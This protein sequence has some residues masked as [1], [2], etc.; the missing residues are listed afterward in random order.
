MQQSGLVAKIKHIWEVKSLHCPFL[1]GSFFPE[2]SFW[3]ALVKQSMNRTVNRMKDDNW[4]H[5]TLYTSSSL[6]PTLSKPTHQPR[7]RKTE[8]AKLKHPDQLL[9]D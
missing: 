4:Q 1:L 5:F 7:S 6:T 3:A 8:P 9:I 2:R